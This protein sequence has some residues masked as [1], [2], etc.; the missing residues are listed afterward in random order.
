MQRTV[1][2]RQIVSVRAQHVCLCQRAILGVVPHPL[3]RLRH[4]LC[5]SLHMPG[6][7]SFRESRAFP[8]LLPQ[9]HWDY[10]HAL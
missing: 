6:P 7:V 4:G 3:S 1:A 2:S 10:R 8:H 9:E 5:Y